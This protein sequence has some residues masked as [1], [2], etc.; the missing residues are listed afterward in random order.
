M[1]RHTFGKLSIEANLNPFKL[2]SIMGHADISTTQIYVNPST[3]NIKDSFQKIN[4][5]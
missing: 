1:L 2:Q 5:L 3:E 4:L